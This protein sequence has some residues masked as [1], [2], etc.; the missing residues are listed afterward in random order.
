VLALV[1]G[2]LPAAAVAAPGTLDPSFGTGGEVTTD[3]GGSDSAEAVAIQ[4]D[5]KI[6]AVGG[7]FSFPSGDFALARYNADG[8]LDPSFGSGGKVTTDFGGF[9]AA[10][11]A[12]IQPDGRIV[13]AG[14]S[15]SG[16]FALAR[17]NT[18]GSLDTTF[19]NGGKLTTDFGGFD[20]AFGV[21]LQ[22][23]GKIV[24]AGQGGPG[25]GFALARYNTDG[26]LDPSF[27][28]GGEVTTHFTS[29]FEVVIAVAIQLDGKIVVTG[30]TFAGGFQQF[31]LARYNTDGSLDTSFA[32]GGIVAT[33]FG[34]D[35]AFGGALAIQP[36]GK[37]VAA[38]RAGTD[39]L[40]AR[41]NGDGSL[42]AT[43]GSG[44]IVTTDFG[45]TVFDAAFGVALQ[46][47]GKIVAA[48]GTFNGFVG[49]SA[50]FALARYNPDGSLD[51]SFGSGGQV[52][53][54]FGGFDVAR[55]VAL[56]A[57]GKI[58]AAGG[59]FN[60]FVGPSADFALARYN[61]DGSLDASFGSGGKVTTDFGG[62]DVAR[63]VALQADGKIVAAGTGGA[64]SDFALARY[65]GDA[66]GADLLITKSGAPNPVVSGNQLTY[67]LTVTDNG[68]QDATGVTVTDPLPASL[69]FNSVA[70]TQG[71][72]VR[73]TT[74]NPQP[75]GGTITCS[76]R[77]LA[78]GASATITIVVT[79]TTPGTL[80][81]T[82]TVSGNETD[83][84][85]SNN[86]ATATTTVIGT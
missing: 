73:S 48:G 75:K 6:V 13:A 45:G 22:A 10:S 7:T 79:T 11:A 28:S 66:V 82:A 18:D 2:A 34:F 35:S 3:F 85:P 20:A 60:G 71:T 1:A 14:R 31:A 32:S 46:S 25:G 86:S 52:T 44:G 36:D 69:H 49:P 38:G 64:G 12:V 8:S 70:S 37:I 83:P 59:T 4:S 72:C 29:G 84:K 51:A 81:N 16:D 65:L 41:Y 33:N 23:D 55:S 19:G 26:S 56:Q 27:G 74:T 62:F 5:G 43:F 9:D 15:G 76:L 39:F 30:Q 24:A 63:S 57:D 61:P 67:T 21:A 54:D 42:D 40:L 77:N 17:Y 53:T 58:V 78:N 68:P 47:N 50:D 80:T